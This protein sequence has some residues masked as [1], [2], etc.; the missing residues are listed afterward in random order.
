MPQIDDRYAEMQA[1]LQWMQSLSCE[2]LRM[3]KQKRKDG[4]T[5]DRMLRAHKSHLDEYIRLSI[6]H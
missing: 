6:T 4:V 2:L 5:V 1:R 3:D